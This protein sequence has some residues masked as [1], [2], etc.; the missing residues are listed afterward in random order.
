MKLNYIML[1][2]NFQPRPRPGHRVKKVS[3]TLSPMSMGGRRVQGEA[4]KMAGNAQKEEV[5]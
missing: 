3:Q 2:K 4:K 5:R 1:P